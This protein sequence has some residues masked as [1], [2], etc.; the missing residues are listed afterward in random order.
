MAVKTIIFRRV[1]NTFFLSYSAK[2]LNGNI[3]TGSICNSGQPLPLPMLLESINYDTSRIVW[4]KNE[5]EAES[6]FQ[7]LRSGKGDHG[8]IN[9]RLANSLARAIH[10]ILEFNVFASTPPPQNPMDILTNLPDG[11]RIDLQLI[12]PTGVGPFSCS[13][14]QVVGPSLADKGI[15]AICDEP[16]CNMFPLERV[17]N[18][19]DHAV[20]SLSGMNLPDDS[21]VELKNSCL[22]DLKELRDGN[23][24]A[25]RRAI[26]AAA[27]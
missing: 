26:E 1:Y 14:I 27:E 17:E 6:D 7:L 9:G 24:L 21:Q 3:V 12:A 13:A 8:Y 16:N 18:H 20:Q 15:M 25:L 19:I 5:S 11:V 2:Q 22:A 10:S 23:L 4:P